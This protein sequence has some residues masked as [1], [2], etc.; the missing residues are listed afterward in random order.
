MIVGFV[1][2]IGCGKGMAGDYLKFTHN[3][4]KDSFAK[5]LKDA[6]SIIFNWDRDLLEGE[7]TESR[8]WREQPDEYWSKKLGYPVIPR[9]VLQKMGTEAGRNIFG[10]DLWIASFE[11]RWLKNNKPNLVITDVRFPNEIHSI[12]SLG[13][14]VIRIKR[15]PD[16]EWYHDVY[17]LLSSNNDADKHVVET[18]SKQGKIPHMS[19]VA[20]IGSSFDYTLHN[21]STT[22]EFQENLERI[23]KNDD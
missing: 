22:V 15:G 14:K 21:D 9:Q 18:W 16:P 23:L 8:K 17:A 1:G 11:A 4:Q 6:V 2:F 3:Y 7:T 13:G 20:W 12:R 10:Y 5:P 19:E